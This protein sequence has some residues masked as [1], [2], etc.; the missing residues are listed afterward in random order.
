MIFSSPPLFYVN[1]KISSVLLTISR[2]Q[3]HRLVIVVTEETESDICNKSE[4][5]NKGLGQ[6]EKPPTFT[7]TGAIFKSDRM[8][9][10][11]KE[12]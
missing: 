1:L 8:D 9:I 10:T 4:T 11:Y 7:K 3:F 6:T 12:T 2:K 5:Y